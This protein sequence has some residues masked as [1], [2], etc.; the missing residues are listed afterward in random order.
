MKFSTF[1]SLLS[2]V[3]MSYAATTSPTTSTTATTEATTETVTTT[4]ASKTTTVVSKTT[5]TES[6]VT[7]S[8]STVN[9]CAILKEIFS[10]ASNYKWYD[11]IDNC[12]S[13]SPEFTCNDNKK[14]QTM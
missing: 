8:P 12:C 7:E 11:N 1:F 3:T 4:T 13:Q 6:E 10:N 5:E 9:E 2:V 14:I